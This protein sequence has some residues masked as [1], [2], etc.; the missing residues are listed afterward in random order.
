M[1]NTSNTP[2]NFQA[3]GLEI[4]Q[5]ESAYE[6]IRKNRGKNR[7]SDKDVQECERITDRL[8]RLYFHDLNITLDALE[9]IK[10]SIV[11]FTENY[12][13][14][15]AD[16]VG[17]YK[18]QE[19]DEPEELSKPERADLAKESK[20]RL[21]KLEEILTAEILPLAEKLR[22]RKRIRLLE[23]NYRPLIRFL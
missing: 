21:E 13:I 17:L 3:I 4:D 7:I 23:E 12:Y 19:P 1:G 16:L 14:H 8:N 5:I 6:Q 20:E 11:A 15:I 2:N 18:S 9:P 10:A 22:L